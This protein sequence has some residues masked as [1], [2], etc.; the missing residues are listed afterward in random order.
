VRASERSKVAKEEVKPR[1]WVASGIYAP[2]ESK[3]TFSL[4]SSDQGKTHT[5]Q[6][7]AAV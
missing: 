7:W 1:G 6:A 4:R 2:L 5:G 3:C